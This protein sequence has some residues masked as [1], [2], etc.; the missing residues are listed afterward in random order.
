MTEELLKKIQ[1]LINKA[2]KAGK[3]EDTIAKVLIIPI[4]WRKTLKLKNR[5]MLS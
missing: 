5:R 3:G 4:S 2:K 1:V